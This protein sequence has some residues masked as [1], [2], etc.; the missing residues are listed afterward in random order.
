M[1]CIQCAAFQKRSAEGFGG[2][3]FEWNSFFLK[4]FLSWRVFNVRHFKNE[5]RRGFWEGFLKGTP[6]FQ[7]Y[8]YHSVYSMRGVSKTKRSEVFAESFLKEVWRELFLEKVPSKVFT[9]RL[10]PPITPTASSKPTADFVSHQAS[11]QTF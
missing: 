9:Q 5:A 8:S 10:K 3:L 4:I 2:R 1:A 7:K 6:F 11:D